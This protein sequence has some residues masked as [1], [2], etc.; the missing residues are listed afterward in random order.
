MSGILV[1]LYKSYLLLISLIIAKYTRF[2]KNFQ[3]THKK[4]ELVKIQKTIPNFEF[5]SKKLKKGKKTKF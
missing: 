2:L 5:L 4:K 3:H 1:K